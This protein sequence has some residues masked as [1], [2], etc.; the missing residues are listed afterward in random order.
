MKKIYIISCYYEPDGSSWNICAFSDKEKAKQM[1]DRFNSQH[2]DDGYEYS[3]ES[4]ELDSE[5][6]E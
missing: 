5:Y 2:D 1:C 4:F 6:E 3:I